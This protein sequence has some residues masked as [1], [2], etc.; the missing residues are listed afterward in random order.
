MKKVDDV[1]LVYLR[2]E[3]PKFGL[4]PKLD[5]TS[6][7]IDYLFKVIKKDQLDFK[8]KCWVAILTGKNYLLGISET[9]AGS[10]KLDSINVKEILQLSLITN[11]KKII[12]IRNRPDGDIRPTQPDIKAA[13][14][15]LEVGKFMDIELLDYILISSETMVSFKNRMIF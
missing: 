6:D 2:Y 7:I 15:L 12:L 5:C 4:L 10:V 8:E 14:D 1:N 11:A 9:Y 13:K 3:R